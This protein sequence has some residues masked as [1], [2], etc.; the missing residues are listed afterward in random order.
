LSPANHRG[1]G[2]FVQSPALNCLC[3][4]SSLIHSPPVKN[5][6]AVSGF[7]VAGVKVGASG[8]GVRVGAGV[9]G[10]GAGVGVGVSAGSGDGLG[11]GTGPQ[12]ARISVLHKIAT[13]ID[14][15]LHRDS[16]NPP[17]LKTTKVF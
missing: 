3:S 1:R 5:R 14:C 4:S 15:T 16:S 8:A 12:A 2:I 10:A 6:A 13:I 11:V 7:R 9:G 17:I